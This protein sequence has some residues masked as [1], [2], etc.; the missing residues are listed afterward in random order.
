MPRFA[1]WLSDMTLVVA[2]VIAVVAD[3][4]AAAK[5]SIRAIVIDPFRVKHLHSQ[6]PLNEGFILHTPSPR[7]L[8][9]ANRRALFAR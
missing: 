5:V 9:E 7:V 1:K 6:D 3:G 2:I 8:P 4:K